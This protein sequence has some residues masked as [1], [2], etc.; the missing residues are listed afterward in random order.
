MRGEVHI[1]KAVQ[2]L[3]LHL[4]CDA[5]EGNHCGMMKPA[6]GPG[7]AQHAAGVI[8]TSAHNSHQ[9]GVWKVHKE[10]N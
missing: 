5:V 9:T 2:L 6:V 7:S 3:L 10:H 8:S 4:C 1:H